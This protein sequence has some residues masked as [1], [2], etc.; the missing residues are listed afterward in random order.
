MFEAMTNN[1][2]V[3]AVLVVLF[4][5]TIF[6]HE[7]GHYL[8]ARLCGLVVEVFSIGFGPAIWK[9]R[10]KGV[11]YQIGCIPVGG[12]VALPQLDPTGMSTIQGDGKPAAGK[13][14]AAPA[15]PRV[16]WWRK[17]VVSLAGATGNFLLAVLLVWVVYWVG[18]PDGPSE[19]SAV[20]GYVDPDSKA[21]AAG[22]RI[23]DEVASVNGVRVAKWSEVRMEAALHNVVM[24]QVRGASGERTITV[25]T[26]RGMLGEQGLRGV[27]G[28]NLCAVLSVAPGMSAEKAGVRSGDTVVEFAGREVFSIGHLIALVE[29]QKD[30]TVSMKIKRVV[31]GKPA[32]VSMSVTPAYDAAS[33]QV[34][35]GIRFNPQA[36]DFD[37]VSHP[38]PGAKL[39]EYATAIFRV[40]QALGTPKQ[41]GAAS[42]A[43]GGP[44]AIVAS[45]WFIVKTSL[46]LAIAF[47]A[48][49]NVNL[50]ILNLLPIPVLDGGHIAF[51][52]WEA[53][54]GRPAHPKVV[55]ALVNVFAAV[56][57][58]LLVLLSG[59]DMDRM[60]P[61]GRLVRNLFQRKAEAAT[62]APSA[63]RAGAFSNAPGGE[64][65]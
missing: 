42:Q 41:A 49:L 46:M 20:A 52:L 38:R 21:Y 63:P 34:R 19:R 55:N 54:A 64:S 17:V 14:E 27:D 35:I 39:R 51:A 60:T 26:E 8:A 6:V 48:F 32:L 37:I 28:R 47:T 30:Q 29:Q 5:V 3:L 22:L 33:K 62:N 65:P 18:I 50:A 10:H 59:R 44:V 56:L 61:V 16:A 43:L 23:G 15:L 12:F 13:T 7:L 53:A 4:G 57:I 24:L 11:V 58:V 45:Y 2:W 36:V 9:R 40:L 1:V 31:D 25:A